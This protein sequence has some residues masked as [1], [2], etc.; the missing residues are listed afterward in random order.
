MKKVG[1]GDWD[2]VFQ[3][4]MVGEKVGNDG[5]KKVV[6]GKSVCKGRW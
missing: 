5:W 4:E 3:G 2:A 1:N 6:E